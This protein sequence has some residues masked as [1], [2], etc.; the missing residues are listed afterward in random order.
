MFDLLF[1]SYTL[2]IVILGTMMLGAV[3]GVVGVFSV[4]R[5]QALI[6]DALSH[7]ALPGVVLAFMF[8]QSKQLYVLLFGAAFASSVSL[9]LLTLIKRYTHIKYDAL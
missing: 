4:L 3:S 1:E 2:Q 6:G 8:T 5:K 9:A 7:A